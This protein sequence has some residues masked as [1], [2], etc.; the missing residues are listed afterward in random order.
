MTQA[1]CGQ[2]TLEQLEY[3][4]NQKTKPITYVQ[5]CYAKC[6][7]NEVLGVELSHIYAPTSF[8][9]NHCQLFSVGS[10][11]VFGPLIFTYVI[12]FSFSF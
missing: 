4:S 2:A 12:L 6:R 10:F 11:T 8:P 9:E 1:I 5:Q 3:F 7:H